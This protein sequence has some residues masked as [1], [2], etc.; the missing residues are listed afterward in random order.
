VVLAISALFILGAG[1]G[2]LDWI[3]PLILGYTLAVIGAVVTIR[4]LMGF[5]DKTTTL[6]PILH[7]KGVDVFVFTLTTVVYVVLASVVGF[8]IM[9]AAFIFGA[10]VYLD[11]ARSG[12][13]IALAAAISLIVCIA[14]YI[15]LLQVFYVPLPPSRFLPF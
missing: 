4:G 11:H 7:G 8:W 5:G 12:K 2:T 1:E 9:T 13:K 10:A 15:L 6:L 3:F 14:A